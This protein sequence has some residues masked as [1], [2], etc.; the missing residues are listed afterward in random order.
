MRPIITEAMFMPI[1]LAQEKELR[2]IKATLEKLNSEKEKQQGENPR[3][4]RIKSISC[5]GWNGYP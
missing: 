1:L 4:E 5:S 3:V 2:K